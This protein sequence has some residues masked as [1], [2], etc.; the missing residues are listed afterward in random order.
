[1][2]ILMFGVLGL[3]ALG[4]GSSSSSP[5]AQAQC[6]TLDQAICAKVFTCAEAASFSSTYGTSQADCV[7]T[8]DATCNA[9]GC[10]TG[11]T[12]HA[13]L[14][15]QCVSATQAVTCTQIGT[16]GESTL[17]PAVCDTVCS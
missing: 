1:M 9:S 2:K 4:C 15:S 16:G 14:A 12:Y 10:P 13:D 5:S 6:K 17:F 11:M 7:T 8:M 3:L